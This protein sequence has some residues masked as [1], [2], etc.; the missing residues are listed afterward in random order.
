[1]VLVVMVLVVL[2]VMMMVDE[3]WWWLYIQGLNVCKIIIKQELFV[4]SGKPSCRGAQ[5]RAACFEQEVW[6]LIA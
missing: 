4:S 3:W 2:V 5:P 1:M 6:Q